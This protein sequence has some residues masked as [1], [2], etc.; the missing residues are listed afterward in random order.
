MDGHG[1]L[2]RGMAYRITNHVPQHV[3]GDKLADI[4]NEMGGDRFCKITNYCSKNIKFKELFEAV[5]DS[6]E[7][8]AI[9]AKYVDAIA[10]LTDVIKEVAE[11][12][13][14][15]ALPLSFIF[16]SIKYGLDDLCNCCDACDGSGYVE[17]NECEKCN[18]TGVKKHKIA[19]V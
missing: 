2:F 15:A 17:E 4:L 11:E 12:I 5:N 14:G 10:W 19:C 7:I 1:W 18:G 6:P 9:L 13:G 3:S 16:M 8:T